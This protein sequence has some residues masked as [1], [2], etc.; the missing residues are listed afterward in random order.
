MQYRLRFFLSHLALS[1]IVVGSA[2]ALV[3]FLWYPPP[4]AQLEGIFSVLLIMVGVDIGAGP[5][6]TLV[7]ASPTKPRAHLVRDLAVIGCVQLAALSYGIH[8]AF[9]ARPAYVVYSVGQ[10]EIEHA[11]EL[12]AAELAKAAGTPFASAPLL[13]PVFVEAR[14][15]TD[16]KAVARIV[17]S[18]IR[19]GPDIKDMPRYYVAWPGVGTDA[20]KYARSV[21][22]VP[23][24]SLRHAI[25]DLLRKRHISA[26]DAMILPI[27]GKVNRGSVVLRRS[28][29]AVIGI[30]L[31]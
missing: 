26:H 3:V 31:S 17:L 14:F 16:K 28:N 18:A 15:P 23:E 24:R 19:G 7:A 12:T 10:F 5:L 22:H 25:G 2:I 8:T 6:C 29:L 21:S 11:N 4:F 1:A 13:G 9:V 20:G 30:V 27:N